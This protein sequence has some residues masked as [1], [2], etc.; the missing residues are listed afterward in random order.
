[1]IIIFELLKL[2]NGSCL[3]ISQPTVREA[4]VLEPECAVVGVLAE[5]NVRP[6]PAERDLVGGSLLVSYGLRWHHDAL[7]R[8]RLQPGCG[9]I[10]DEGGGRDLPVPHEE[11]E[12]DGAQSLAVQ[13]QPLAQRDGVRAMDVAGGGDGP[14]KHL[15]AADPRDDQE[16]GGTARAAVQLQQTGARR[17]H[18]RRALVCH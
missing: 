7:D 2:A 16:L 18:P 13:R 15:V 3:L 1:M 14:G 17:G 11:A 8:R 9:G 5:H 6:V 12:S 10:L 4:E